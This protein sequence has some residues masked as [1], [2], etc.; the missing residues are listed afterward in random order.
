MMLQVVIKV[1]RCI[2]YGNR[3]KYAFVPKSQE[4]HGIARGPVFRKVVIGKNYAAIRRAVN[5]ASFD[6][7][8][9]GVKNLNSSTVESQEY[10]ACPLMGPHET[11]FRH[12]E[13]VQPARESAQ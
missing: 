5:D 6:G 4:Q 13:T 11:L 2:S 9:L 10:V 3:I 1:Q 12:I 8:T 7:K